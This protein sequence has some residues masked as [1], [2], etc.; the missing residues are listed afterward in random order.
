MFK[1]FP[2][3]Y[4]WNLSVDLAIPYDQNGGGTRLHPPCC[5]HAALAAIFGSDSFLCFNSSLGCHFECDADI[6]KH[7]DSWEAPEVPI[8]L[9]ASQVVP[10]EMRENRQ[11]ADL[12]APKAEAGSVQVRLALAQIREE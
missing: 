5:R 7:D 1:Y 10:V 11:P 8:R 6:D 2:T 9:G 12:V 4:V 3:S